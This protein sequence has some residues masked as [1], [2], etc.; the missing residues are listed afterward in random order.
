MIYGPN[1]RDQQEERDLQA[2]LT[3]QQEEC[4]L[5]A[6]FTSPSRL[7]PVANGPRNKARQI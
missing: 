2:Y 4:D 7:C 3:D 6:E 1:V 5:Q